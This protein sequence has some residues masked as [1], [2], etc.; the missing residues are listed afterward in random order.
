MA[1]RRCISNRHVNAI[2][3]RKITSELKIAAVAFL[4]SSLQN[5]RQKGYVAR[6]RPGRNIV[7]GAI[8]GRAAKPRRSL[9]RFLLD[10]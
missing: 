4:W 6:L 5:E 7:H 9:V 2:I 8:V 3:A 1:Y 10:A